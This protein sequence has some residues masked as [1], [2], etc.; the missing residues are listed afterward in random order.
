MDIG[1]L[2]NTMR[3]SAGLPAHPSIFQALML[4]TWMFHI[5]FVHLTLGAAGL[6]IWAYVRRDAHP[7]WARLSEAMTKVAKVG[8][9]LLIVLGVAPLLF[10]QVIYD[11]QWYA[12]NVLSARWAIAFI[13]TLIVAYCMWFYFYSQNHGKSATRFLAIFAGASMGL[14]VLDGLIMHVLS[15]QAL[16]PQQWHEWYAPGGVVDTSGS[17]LHAMQPLRFLFIMGL[18]VPA[19]GLFLLAYA[20]YC[21]DRADAD[22]A[23]LARVRELGRTIACRGLLMSAVLMLGWQLTNPWA[24]ALWKQPLGWI[25]V[26]WCIALALWLKRKTSLQQQ[27]YV[28]LSAGFGLVGLLAV[29][30]EVIRMTYLGNLGY[31]IADYPVHVDWPSM[32]LFGATL[33]GVGGLVG[34]FYLRLLYQAGRSVGVYEA[35]SLTSR[36]GSAAVGI[37]VVWITVFFAYG[38]NIYIGNIFK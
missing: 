12:S 15:Y 11:P 19:V 28:A 20:D 35:D 10:T 32:A 25:L 4:L 8:V 37:M 2:M 5:A 38:I 6:A 22:K 26:L 33:L 9:S 34:G 27:G 17:H 36:W 1:L 3:D 18:S 14:F 31:H 13:F 30:R 7:H 21:S 29:W 23:Y 16:L 24:L